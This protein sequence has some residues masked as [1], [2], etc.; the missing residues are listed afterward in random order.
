[1]N[2]LRPLDFDITH[3]QQ[4]TAELE[5]NVNAAGIAGYLR[6]IYPEIHKLRT[7]RSFALNIFHA[8][9]DVLPFEE[10]GLTDDD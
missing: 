2:D 3:L 10:P 9:E 4:F 5:R 6:S 1:M 7:Q 8:L